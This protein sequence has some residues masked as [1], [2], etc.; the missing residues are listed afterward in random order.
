[1]QAHV[2]PRGAVI[3]QID[4]YPEERVLHVVLLVGKDLEQWETSV[5][6]RLKSFA[7]A[8]GCGAIEANCR[9]GLARFLKKHG[10]RRTK[11][12]MRVDL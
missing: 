6:D 7:I 4:N 9:P 10:F 12:I 1:M 3:T 8:H 2:F 11:I 5:L